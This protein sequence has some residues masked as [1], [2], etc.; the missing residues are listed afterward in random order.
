MTEVPVVLTQWWLGEKGGSC[1]ARF[2]M[3]TSPGGSLG[4]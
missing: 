1:S 4:R 2:Q 3:R